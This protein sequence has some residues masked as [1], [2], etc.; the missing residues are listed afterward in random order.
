V[1]LKTKLW[2]EKDYFAQITLH[3][4]II[5]FQQTQQINNATTS[6]MEWHAKTEIEQ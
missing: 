2:D 3:V 6:K 4:R 5:M 1:T